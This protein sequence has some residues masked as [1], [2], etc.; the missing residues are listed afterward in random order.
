MK[1]KVPEKFLLIQ[2]RQIGDVILTTP[3]PAILRHHF[4]HSQIDFLTFSVNESIWRHNPNISNLL[5][6]NKKDGFGAFVKLLRR[7]YGNHYDAVLDFQNT[8]R[9]TYCSLASFAQYRVTWNKSSRRMLYNTLVPSSDNYPCAAKCNFLTPFLHDNFSANDM[10]PPKPEVFFSDTEAKRID[11]IFDQYDLKPNDLI[12]TMAPTHR[13]IVRRW[14]LEFF[15]EAAKYL[16]ETYHAKVILSWGPG[17]ENYIQKGI[18][19]GNYAHPNLISDL[20]LNLL[21]L[22]ALMKRCKFHLG[23]DSAPMHLAVTQGLPTF[24]IFGATSTSWAYPSLRHVCAQKDM[25]CQ[26][27][28]KLECRFGQAIPCLKEFGFKEIQPKLDQFIQTVVMA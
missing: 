22:A 8:P 23:N 5:I 26:P 18:Q 24:S 16:I 27:C 12:V 6:F 14:P 10:P 28:N 11:S 20:F 7:I 25:D 3:I 21:E 1:K 15:L 9:S 19:A 4:P 2:F 17:E 13:R